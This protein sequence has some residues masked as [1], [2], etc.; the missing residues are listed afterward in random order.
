MLFMKSIYTFTCLFVCLLLGSGLFAQGASL[1]G[2]LTDDQGEALIGATILLEGT[3]KGSVSDVD[4]NYS[5]T[6]IPSG[7]YTVNFS[8]LGYRTITEQITF[9]E[10]EAIIKSLT[11]ENDA[12]L[13]DEAVVVGFGKTYAKDLTGSTKLITAKDF[14]AGNVTTPEQLIMGK[15]SGVQIT[16]N[17][18]APGAGSRIRI[19]GGTSLNASNSPLIVVDGVPLDN[20]SISG[21]ADPLNLI[22]PSEIENIVILKDASAAA[23]YGSRGANGV[24]LI[25]TKKGLE[26]KSKLTVNL[27]QTVSMAQVTKTADAMN[28]DELRQA[29]ATYG[30]DT[31]LA[32]LGTENTDWQKEI[33]RN[34][35]ISETNIGVSGGINNLPYRFSASY[36]NEDGILK[37]HNLE[38]TSVG[39]NLTPKL[40]D[41]LLVLE[42]NTK[43]TYS[44]NFFADQGA[45]GSAVAFD[46]TQPVYSGNDTLYGGYYEWLNPNSGIPNNLAIKNPVGL[47]NQKEDV[48][49]VNRFIGNVK[50]DLAVPLVPGLHAILNLGGDYS[51]GEGSVTIPAEAASQFLQGGERSQ[52][53]QDK[54]NRVLESYFNYNKGLGIANLDL[55]AGYSYQRWERESPAFPLLN[56]AGDTVRPAGIPFFTENVLISYYG[57]AKI[58]LFDKYLITGTLRRD[59]SSRFN[60][61]QRWGLFPSVALGWRISEESFLKSVEA[62]SYLKLRL[63][64]GI[65]GQQDVN[66]DYPYLANYTFSTSTAQYQFGN[67]FY[68]LLRPDGFDYNIKWEET[69]STNIG[70]DWGFAGN[71]VFGAIDYYKKETSDLLAVVDVPA[72]ANFTNQILTNIG[73]MT[74]E[75]LELELSVVAI[76]QSDF[77]L[78]LSGNFTMNNN[79]ITK[80]NRIEDSTSVGILVEGINGGIGN[81]V[82]IQAVGHPSNSFYV[83]EQVYDDVGKPVEGEFVDRNLDGVINEM[84]RYIY[85]KA[86]PDFFAGFSANLSYKR[87]SAGFSMRGE[88]GRYVYNNVH[89]ER[90][91][92]NNIPAE[93]HIFNLHNAFNETNFISSSPEQFLSDYYVEKADFIRMDF[94]NVG[95]NFGN[96]Y[97][98]RVALNV[99]FVVN[100]VFVWSDYKGID[101]EITNG[102]DKNIYPRP[103]IYSLTFNM[104]FK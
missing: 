34:A 1:S 87:W 47:L 2:Q 91:W 6:N 88:F 27:Q 35:L 68:E 104:T 41:N 86:V 83:Y 73:S 64:Y 92:F 36:K 24:I 16:S 58:N 14:T 98:D 63:G 94:L 7:T 30:T 72:G 100:N 20:E 62:L 95:Y 97:K 60:P 49:T 67:Q 77:N 5:I 3:T 22:N 82:Q 42:V 33:Y 39:L 61:D 78:T 23:I 31:Q 65:T 43:Y 79:E 57:R 69:A 99:G 29:I 8:F 4:G 75:G 19:R 96:I 12:M 93:N 90:G 21:A 103:R 70:L 59:G 40:F 81:N 18:G 66:N 26:G 45:I 52:Y 55:T 85:E 32:L 84:D 54:N 50:F 56:I 53:E 46:P 51:H 48:S 38:R 102:V 17:S 44:S 25:T 13:L 15:A 11:L 37:R 10:G 28:A 9:A 76:Q 101:P 71:R 80:L 74:N 89:S